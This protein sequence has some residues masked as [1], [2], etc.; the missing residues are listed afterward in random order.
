MESRGFPGGSDG[1]ES[2]SNA[3]DLSS[4]PRSGRPLG[5]GNTPVL[6]SGE[7]HGLR[8]L[9]SFSPWGCRK[10]DTAGRLTLSLFFLRFLEK[11]TTEADRICTVVMEISTPWKEILVQRLIFFPPIQEVS[12]QST[13]SPAKAFHWWSLLEWDCAV[14]CIGQILCPFTEEQCHPET[15][16]W[17]RT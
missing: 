5:E 8:N 15:K 1:K 16:L 6:L 9:A 13:F 10:L 11:R 7:S 2:A 12:L 3:G 4:I 14:S 17:T